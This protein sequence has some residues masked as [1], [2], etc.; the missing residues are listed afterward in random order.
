DRQLVIDLNA[1]FGNITIYDETTY[2]Q[3]EYG[4]DDDAASSTTGYPT[5]G[6]PA[7]ADRGS[8]ENT[9]EETR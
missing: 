2:R 8:Q 4:L 3:E 9:V 5:P 7:G 1:A 6:A